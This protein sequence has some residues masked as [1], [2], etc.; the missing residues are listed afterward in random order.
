MLG[1]QQGQHGALRAR[2]AAREEGYRAE[3]RVHD[4]VAGLTAHEVGDAHEGGHEGRLGSGV[5]DLGR[6]HL[7]DAPARH[8][9]HEVGDG[10]RL[11]LVMGHEDGAL[12]CLAQDLS[13]LAAEL[14]AHRLVQARERLV[15]Q[16]HVGSGGQGT[17]Q[18]HALLHAARELV[19]VAGCIVLQPDELEQ[20]S[21]SH[22][23]VGVATDAVGHVLSRRQV[24][25]ERQV[26]EDEARTTALRR[27]DGGGGRHATSTDVDGAG[28]R[29]FE[30]ADEPK[31]GRLAATRR[32]E[33]GEHRA[34]CELQVGPVESVNRAVAL[35]DAA[36]RDRGRREHARCAPRIS[37][38][39]HPLAAS[40]PR[41]RRATDSADTMSRI[42]AGTAA[43][44]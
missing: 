31:A 39:A 9:G 30:A 6:G 35:A 32:P 40:L 19:R 23:T 2:S 29:A 8:D 13:H 11:A 26:L 10:Q 34:G 21:R 12:A 44:V 4:A 41:S 16:Q 15:E 3:A 42:A 1:A 14:R 27:H 20:L 37:E 25:E 43:W 7:F 36:H 5:D 22:V 28:V 38:A 24:R 33:E 17:G 18:G